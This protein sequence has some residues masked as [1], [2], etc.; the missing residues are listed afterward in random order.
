MS[1]Y[2]V[3]SCIYLNL[4]KKEVDESGDLLWKFA[5]EFFEKL[6]D[7]NSVIYYSGYLLRE[8][9]F[10]FDEKQF[11]NKLELFNYSS[12]FKRVNLTKEEYQEAQKLK[13]TLAS[14]VSFFDILHTLFAKKTNSVLVTRD[15]DLIEFAK[16]MNIIVKKPEELL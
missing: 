12:I 9:M 3:D 14:N 13:N 6:E 2:Y 11:I 8:L 10:A 16:T 5:K 7:N 15:E 1:G 4:W